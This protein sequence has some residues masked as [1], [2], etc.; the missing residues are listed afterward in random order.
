[1]PQGQGSPLSNFTFSSDSN[2][3]FWN[4]RRGPNVRIFADNQPVLDGGAP[5]PG[6]QPQAWQPDGNSGLVVLGSL[7]DN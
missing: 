4:F 3:L 5:S 2:H 7:L 6:G 1:M